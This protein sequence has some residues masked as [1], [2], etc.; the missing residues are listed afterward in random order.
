MSLILNEIHKRPAVE[1]CCA[2]CLAV[3]QIC[4]CCWRNQ[5]YCSKE[6][7]R[8]ATKQRHRKNQKAYRQTE[9][10]R[11]HHSAQQ[12]SYRERKKIPRVIELQTS[13][14]IL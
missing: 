1:F 5:R 4:Q 13:S 6:C 10:G 11:A 7:S 14:E 12:K 8:E 2:Q 3:V 9:A